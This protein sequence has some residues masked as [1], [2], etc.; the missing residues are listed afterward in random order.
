MAVAGV[1]EPRHDAARRAAAMALEVRQAV[2]RLELRH[3]L[4]IGVRIGIASG[5]LTAGVIG[6]TRFTYDV[7]GDTV[8]LAARLEQ[9]GQRGSI[10]VCGETR[11]ALGG[12]YAF[13]RREIEIRGFGTK[14]TW[15]MESLPA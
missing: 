2:E 15:F 7:W 3:A 8:N 13:K 10:H 9:T 6:T 5:P 1:P 4:D 14:E 11:R 12:A